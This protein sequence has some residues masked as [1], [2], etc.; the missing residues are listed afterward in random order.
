MRCDC[1]A[2]IALTHTRGRPRKV[3]S[4][5]RPSKASKP[6]V[7]RQRSRI[8]AVC[9]VS[10]EGV[11]GAKYCSD[12]CKWMTAPRVACSVC[13]GPTGWRASRT[14]VSGATCRDCRSDYTRFEHGTRRGYKDAG[15]RCVPCV[16]W[17]REKDRAYA[18]RRRAEG[19][20]IKRFGSSGPWI[21]EKTRLAVFERDA[22][23][24]QLCNGPLDRSAD[25]NDNL[26]PSIDHVVPQSKGGGHEPDNLR[27]AHRWCN[28]VR[29]DKEAA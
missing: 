21:N 26:F 29:R 23:I 13:G 18:D 22:W 6:Y 4:T 19:R 10:F 20:P 27:A 15:C 8:C 3:C 24:C 2:E 11:A 12:S 5:C 7:P 1:G 14:D 25:P 17:N 9:G 28:S 16:S